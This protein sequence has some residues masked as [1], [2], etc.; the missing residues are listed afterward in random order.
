MQ[1]QEK[2][3]GANYLP[4]WRERAKLTQEQLAEKVGTTGAVISLLESG[5]RA[6]SA[7]WLRRL[8]PELG[9][10]EGFLLQYHPDNVPADLLQAVLD[11]PEEDRQRVLR[12]ISEF[13]K[14]G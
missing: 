9:T 1:W 12:I 2:N 8:A 3:G 4:A 7:K 13:R 5:D 10:T 14:V 6:L 11:V